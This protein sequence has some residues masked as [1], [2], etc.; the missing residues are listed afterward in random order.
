MGDRVW[1]GKPPRRRTR[2][3]GL[4]SLSPSSVAG[5]NEYPEKA[6]GVNRHI[7]WY[8]SP[9]PWSHSVVLVPGWT[10]WLAEI[11][12]DLREAVAHHRHICDNVPHHYFL[13]RSIN[14]M[15]FHGGENVWHPWGGG[16]S[17]ALAST[18]RPHQSCCEAFHVT[19][20]Q[21]NR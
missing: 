8:T 11:S 3:P 19:D 14:F 1:T 21:T 12:A 17:A 16:H 7:T 10:S 2:H 4:L 13:P 6:G 18:L 9:Y 15:G 5:W 20:R